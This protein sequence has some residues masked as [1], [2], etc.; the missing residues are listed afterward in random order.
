MVTVGQRFNLVDGLLSPDDVQERSRTEGPGLETPPLHAN[1]TLTGLRG[2][3]K[4]VLLGEF[5]AR[6][7]RAG[8]LTLQ[9]ELGDRHRDDLQFAEAIVED[10][11]A[12]IGRAD[13]IAAVGQTIERTARWLRPELEAAQARIAELDQAERPLR[14]TTK[15]VRQTIDDMNGILDHAPLAT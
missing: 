6:A 8:W 14:I 10:A 5:A 4:T 9:R 11:E 1:C 3:G 15:L 7:E 2:T 13:A 12:L